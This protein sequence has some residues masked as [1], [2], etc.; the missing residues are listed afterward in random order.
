MKDFIILPDCTCDLSKEAMADIGM[1][2]YIPGHV[3][4]NGIEYPTTLEWEHFTRE[5]YYKT[6][7]NKKAKVT[8]APPSPAEFAETFEKYVAQGIAVISICLSSKISST[9]GFAVSAAEEVRAKYPEA[10]IY[11]FD[12]YRMSGGIG[13]LTYYAYKLQNEGKS[14][15]EVVAW[16]EE[17][18]TRVHQMGP[19]DDLI[20]VARRGRISMGKAIM[21]SFAGVK[22]MGDCN[23]DGYTSVLTKAKGIGK[24]LDITVQ[25]VKETATDIEEQYL[26]VVHSDREL[27]AKTLAEKLEA[28]NPKKIYISDVYSAC[29]AN[30][31]P[32]MIGV[33][34]LGDKISEDMAKEKEIMSRIV[35]K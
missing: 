23:A 17:N 4:F 10:K 21:G 9:Y 8:T 7:S 34:Y 5:E 2:D 35:G 3:N 32:G 28:L 20:F 18:K 6:L 1:T 11:C 30:I 16:L 29:G 12:S 33:Y 14:F 19:I 13:L 27:Y 25:Y 22:P 15:D 26:F 31:G 24:A